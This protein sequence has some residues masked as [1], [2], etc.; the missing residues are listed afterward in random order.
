MK[1]RTS[2]RE[3]H[4]LLEAWIFI[5]LAFGIL[6]NGGNL[7]SLNIIKSVIFAS[8]TVGSG[9][10]LHELGHKIVAQRYGCFAEF[11]ANIQ[12]LV[13]ALI[14]S[15][16]GF[17]IAAPGAV[18]ISGRVS[19]AQNGKIS[20]AGPVMNIFLSL[21]FLIIF[22]LANS[23]GLDIIQEL[24][25]YGV[26]VNAFLAFFNMLPFFILDGKKV[27]IWSKKAYAAVIVPSLLILFFAVNFISI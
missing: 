21:F 2:K 10:L 26:W 25:S 18:M 6:L 20:I 22:F 1:I 24:A 19:R 3:I 8:F 5:S 7:F 27:L 23:F 13:L 14:M 16:F 4:D 17:L 15:F 9:F 11:R 12:M